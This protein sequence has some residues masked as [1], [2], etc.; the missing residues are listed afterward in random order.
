[1]NE[2]QQHNLSFGL[3]LAAAAIIIIAFIVALMGST[4]GE[5]AAALATLIAGILALIAGALVYRAAMSSRN[6]AQ[7]REKDEDRRCKLNPF[8][9]AEHMAYILMQVAPLGLNAARL[10]FSKMTP[11]GQSIPG[12]MSAVEIR[13][14]RPRQ[15]DEL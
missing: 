3:G 6:D 9:K 8:L 5:V 14:P 11:D 15:L 2:N 7:K 13:I 12:H 1:M 10:A 4:S